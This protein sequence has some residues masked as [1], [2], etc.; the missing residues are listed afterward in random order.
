[1]ENI[2]VKY[3][4]KSEQLM[5]CGTEGLR[6][7]QHAGHCVIKFSAKVEAYSG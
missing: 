7:F 4:K 6:L 5:F 1:M 2:L 3:L